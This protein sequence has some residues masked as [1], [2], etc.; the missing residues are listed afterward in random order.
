MWVGEQTIARGIL[1]AVLS[2]E[3][4]SAA[5]VLATD[6]VQAGNATARRLYYVTVTSTLLNLDE[7]LGK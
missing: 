3:G 5:G 2:L 7:A 4:C 6:R 1:V